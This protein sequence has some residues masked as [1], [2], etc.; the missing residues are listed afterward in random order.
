MHVPLRNPLACAILKA[1]WE[2][3]GFYE[4]QILRPA[5]RHASDGRLCRFMEFGRYFH[6][7]DLLASPADFRRAESD[8]C[9]RGWSLYVLEKSIF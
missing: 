5:D 6:Q 2:R 9:R 1:F 3:M 8:R 7:A 4:N